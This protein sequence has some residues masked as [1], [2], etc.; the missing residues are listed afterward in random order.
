MGLHDW[1]AKGSRGPGASQKTWRNVPLEVRFGCNP[2]VRRGIG[3]LRL[4]NTEEIE[5]SLN[6]TAR[7]CANFKRFQTGITYLQTGT[8]LTV[9]NDSVIDLEFPLRCMHLVGPGPKIVKFS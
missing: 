4:I 8:I 9:L 1:P 6:C 3:S 5:I 7:T 2:D